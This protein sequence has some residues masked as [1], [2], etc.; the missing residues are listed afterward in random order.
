MART[1]GSRNKRTTDL[2][3][4]LSENQ[5]KGRLSPV[6]RMLTR[7]WDESLPDDTRDQLARDAA[8]YCH[9]KIAAIELTGKD[10]GPVETKELSNVEVARRMAFVL[11]K[12]SQKT[13]A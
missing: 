8:P 12:A 13:D 1:K 5:E 11:A 7:M 4:F 6:Q 9:A 3:D 2:L 10:G